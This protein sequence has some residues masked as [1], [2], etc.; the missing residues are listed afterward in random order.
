MRTQRRRASEDMALLKKK[1]K[2]KTQS[3][4]NSGDRVGIVL[5][6]PKAKE[7]GKDDWSLLQK[8]GKRKPHCQLRSQNVEVPTGGTRLFFR[9]VKTLERSIPHGEHL[10]SL[11]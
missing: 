7:R 9:R 6:I 2:Q 11:I 5:D 3:L 1:N 4:Q 10:E 8:E